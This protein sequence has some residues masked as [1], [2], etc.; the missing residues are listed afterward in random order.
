MWRRVEYKFPG[1]GWYGGKIT[2]MDGSKYVVAFD[3]GTE[4][5]FGYEQ[6]VRILIEEEEEEGFNEGG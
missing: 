2:G 5:K 3:D 4:K 6:V 1:Y